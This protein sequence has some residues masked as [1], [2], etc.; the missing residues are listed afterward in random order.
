VKAR[1]VKRLDPQASLSENAA[2]IVGMRLAEL[3]SFVPAAFDPES[4]A[5]QHDMRIA[6]KRLRY[7]LECT[8]LCL[9]EPARNARNRTRELQDILGEIHDC[10]VM[11][12]RVEAHVDQIRE[13]DVEALHRWGGA[14]AFPD[15]DLAL[16]AAGGTST[17][18]LDVLAVYLKARRRLL[19]DRFIEFW[20]EQ[21][22]AGAWSE[23]EEVAGAVMNAAKNRRRAL[24]RAQKATRELAAAQREWAAVTEA[25]PG[26]VERG[27][28]LGSGGIPDRA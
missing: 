2:R 1:R 12:P 23:L 16:A 15:H 26:V 27:S 11:L 3:R 7:V 19:V 24:R 5:E 14:G 6:A 17:R 21:E 28:T 18:G 9:G 25:G 4:S 10:D 13:R 20:A 22:R 8:G